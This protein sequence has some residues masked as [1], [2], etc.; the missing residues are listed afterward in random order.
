[1]EP[2][3]MHA[4]EKQLVGQPVESD[5]TVQNAETRMPIAQLQRAVQA[6]MADFQ[7]PSDFR[8][9]SDYRQESGMNLAYRALEEA[10]N[11]SRWRGMAGRNK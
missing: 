10:L 6:G 1:M 3:R 11:I 4:V 9:S 5:T 8:A 7:P 2:L